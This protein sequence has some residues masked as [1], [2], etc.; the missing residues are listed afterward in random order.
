MDIKNWRKKEFMLYGYMCNL[1]V[2][3]TLK[4]LKH[5]NMHIVNVYWQYCSFLMKT[6]MK[7]HLISFLAIFSFHINEPAFFVLLPDIL[8]N[9]SE[10]Q[11]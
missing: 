3:T 5:M 6:N 8:K 2:E 4:N 7:H 9:E 1:C 11:Q 10:I